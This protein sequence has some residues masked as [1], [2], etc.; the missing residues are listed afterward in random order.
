MTIPTKKDT[1]YDRQLR[2]WA[3]NGQAALET[4]HVCLIGASPLG[5]EIVKNLIL[6]GLG[7]L[8]IFDKH[9]VSENDLETNFFIENDKL[10]IPRAQA[11]GECLAELNSSLE[12]VAV[13][14]D[15]AIIAG[16]A[17]LW[18]KFSLIIICEQQWNVVQPISQSVFD[19]NIPVMVVDAAGFYGTIRVSIKEHTIMETHPESAL[20]LRLDC[21][22]PELEQ[23]ALSYDLNALDDSDHEHVPYIVVLLN[24]ISKGKLPSTPAERSELKKKLENDQ[25]VVD[26]ENFGEAIAAVWRLGKPTRV[27]E[28]VLQLCSDP[29]ASDEYIKA[30]QEPFWVFVAALREY[31][32]TFHQLPLP[33]KL[34]D[35][36]ADTRSYVQLQEIYTRK[37]NE[38]YNNYCVILKQLMDRLQIDL[39]E[40]QDLAKRLC[41]QANFLTVVKGVGLQGSVQDEARMCYDSN[42]EDLSNIYNALLATR[43]GKHSIPP[44]YLSEEVF[45]EAERFSDPLQ[46]TAAILGGVAGQECI[47]LITHQYLPLDN[48]FVYDGVHS[49]T[50]SAKY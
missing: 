8:T 18:T 22:W 14:E 23:F 6:P 49:Q 28:T 50:Y 42:N 34:P 9:I 15:V 11:C 17:S 29:H 48:T 47:K 19:S 39:P 36:K 38:D 26:Q 13:N 16:Q 12:W 30:T 41:L 32:D 5:C 2:L 4:A 33:G 40:W 45:E 44:V 43:N 46:N 1:R 3:Q 31:I 25:R 37:A 24:Y 10:G 27:P 21:P 20:D 7:K 35:M